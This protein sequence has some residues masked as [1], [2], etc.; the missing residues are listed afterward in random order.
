MRSPGYVGRLAASRQ[1][2][3]GLAQTLLGVGCRKGT[4]YAAEDLATGFGGLSSTVPHECYVASESFLGV[5]AARLGQ[6][7]G[8][9]APQPWDG[10][11]HGAEAYSRMNQW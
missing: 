9:V 6:R 5:T 4:H 7:R 3:Y 10:S 1:R 2:Q 11:S 8:L